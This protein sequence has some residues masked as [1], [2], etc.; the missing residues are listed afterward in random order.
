IGKTKTQIDKEKKISEL[1]EILGRSETWQ[2]HEIA[3]RIEN[4]RK[5][6]KD[7]LDGMYEKW[8]ELAMLME[9]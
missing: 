4:E 2:D 7:E 8:E 9:E 5:A 3:M 1:E 6:M